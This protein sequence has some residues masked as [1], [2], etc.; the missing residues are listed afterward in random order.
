M[1]YE[2]GLLILNKG[3]RDDTTP[4][5][6]PPLMGFFVGCEDRLFNGRLLCNLLSSSIWRGSFILSTVDVDSNGQFFSCPLLTC[7]STV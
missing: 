1:E 6:G 2:F 7:C 4:A 3:A 5:L